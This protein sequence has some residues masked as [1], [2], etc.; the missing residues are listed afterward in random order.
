M[1]PISR[2]STVGCCQPSATVLVA[3]SCA[4]YGWSE[5]RCN[6]QSHQMFVVA[7]GGDVAVA[8]GVPVVSPNGTEAIQQ[9]FDAGIRRGDAVLA[10]LSEEA[11]GLVSSGERYDDV[12]T[13]FVIE[14]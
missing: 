7:E 14:P 2:K 9:I 10:Q 5:L 11:V 8:G 6:I 12:A 1:R 13:Q 3:S 4:E